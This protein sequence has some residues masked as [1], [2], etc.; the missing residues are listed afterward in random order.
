MTGSVFLFCGDEQAPSTIAVKAVRGPKRAFLSWPMRGQFSSLKL[1][2]RGRAFTS[3][4]RSSCHFVS[5]DA[6]ETPS[7][8]N[9]IKPS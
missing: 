1:D 3:S 6:V 4:T 7:T 9:T 8:T 2:H 5:L